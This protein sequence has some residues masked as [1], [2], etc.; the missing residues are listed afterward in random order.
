MIEHVVLE[1]SDLED[2]EQ[3]KREHWVNVADYLM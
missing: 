3:R 1:T 2:S